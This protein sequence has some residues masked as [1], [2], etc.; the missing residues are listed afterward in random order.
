MIGEF[1]CGV[2]HEFDSN[3]TKKSLDRSQN[4]LPNEVRQHLD[5]KV[6][7][8]KTCFNH[9]LHKLIRFQK[10]IESMVNTSNRSCGNQTRCPDPS[11]QGNVKSVLSFETLSAQLFLWASEIKSDAFFVNFE[12]EFPYVTLFLNLLNRGKE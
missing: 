8:L 9:L 11:H 7:H 6:Q 1:R 12:T 4:H 3:H 10:K 2:K 5:G